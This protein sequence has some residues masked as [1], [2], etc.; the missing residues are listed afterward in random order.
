MVQ[1]QSLPSDVHAHGRTDEDFI[2][3]SLL[4]QID[5]DAD[6]DPVFSSDS[7]AAGASFR[8]AGMH[9][10]RDYGSS[11]SQSSVESS[12]FPYQMMQARSQVP[13]R[14]DSPNGQR[15]SLVYSSQNDQMIHTPQQMLYNN[16]GAEQPSEF[17]HFPSNDNQAF[18]SATLR[19]NSMYNTFGP[20]RGRQGVPGSSSSGMVNDNNSN[21]G[22]FSGDVFGSLASS[23]QQQQL[24]N[25]MRGYDF[26]NE[27][28]SLKT[29][30]AKSN[31]MFNIDPFGN[32]PMMQSQ[33]MNK[34]MQSQAQHLQL[35]NLV[36][37]PFGNNMMQG[38]QQAQ[39]QTPFGPHVNSANN[40]NTLTHANG[41][42]TV[43]VTNQQEE[44]STIFVVG[45][46][47][48]MQ[49]CFIL[50]FV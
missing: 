39:S 8:S 29:G 47:E 45:F 17:G 31:N 15:G 9:G 13:P 19:S 33:Q 23:Q 40:G 30:G 43:S 37:Q 3:R 16:P 50:R 35:H 7:E 24:P 14:G 44:I 5:T 22:Q 36:N 41:M 46:P 32:N 26:M 25:G 34:Q 4:N 42:G 12:A 11:S 28:P 18:D 48:D 38:S 49:A 21:F 27:G 2:N 20:S 6:T 1:Q 10:G